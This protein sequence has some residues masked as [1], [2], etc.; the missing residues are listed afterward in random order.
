MTDKHRDEWEIHENESSFSVVNLKNMDNKLNQLRNQSKTYG[1][2]GIV[3]GGRGSVYQ[4]FPT[5]QWK[6][7]IC[8]GTVSELGVEEDQGEMARE[9]PKTTSV[10][11]Y[12]YFTFVFWDRKNNSER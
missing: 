12:I 4:L 5:N 7:T 2:V 3:Y 10:P 9:P 1:G 8:F 6:A 11:A